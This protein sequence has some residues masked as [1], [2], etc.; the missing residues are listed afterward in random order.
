[1]TVVELVDAGE[2][3]DSDDGEDRGTGCDGKVAV[4]R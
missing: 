1:M 2:V 4:D 3:D